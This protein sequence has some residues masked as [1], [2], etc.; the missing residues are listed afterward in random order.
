M[1]LAPRTNPSAWAGVFL[2]VIGAGCGSAV[3]TETPGVK[4]VGK[5]VLHY[6]GP[7]AE[8]VLSYRAASLRLGEEW[9]FLD[10]AITGAG[11]TPVELNR[12]KIAV[13]TPSGETIALADQKEFGR[14]YP[15]LAGALARADIAGEP[16]D[17]FA[18]RRPKGLDL[19]VA[20]GT[21]LAFES[22]WVNDLEVATGR[23]CFFVPGGVQDG[24]YELRIDLQESRVRIPFRLGGS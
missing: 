9:L 20:P 21:G 4:R 12:G 10:V 2:L 16:V 13:R 11:R 14:A 3:P 24:P 22:V 18:G 7:E 19:L 23:L 6:T 5:T 8:V 15:R 17:Y 1:G